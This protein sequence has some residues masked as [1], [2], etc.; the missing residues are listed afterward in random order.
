MVTLY[1][2]NKI[3]VSADIDYLRERI[4]IGDDRGK[5]PVIKFNPKIF[6][7][8]SGGLYPSIDIYT[9]QAIYN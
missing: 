4:K 9:K 3:S 1:V 8:Y 5:Y 7:S 6:K 2:D